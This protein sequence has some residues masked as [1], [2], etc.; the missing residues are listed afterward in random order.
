MNRRKG[1]EKEL[2]WK[3]H[4]PAVKKSSELSWLLDADSGLDF[5]FAFAFGAVFRAIV[6]IR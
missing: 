5:A 4:G 2:A 1:S 6:S 3:T